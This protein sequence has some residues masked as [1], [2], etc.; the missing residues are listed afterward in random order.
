MAVEAHRFNYSIQENVSPANSLPYLPIRLNY[1]T[2]AVDVSALLD[3]GAT[4]NVLPY[5]IGLELGAIWEEQSTSVKLSGN[6]AQ[7]EAKALIV[8]GKLGNFP[9]IRLAFAWTRND[10]IPV[11]LGQVNFFM[12]FDVCFFRSQSTFEI[13]PK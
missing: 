7:Q 3:T 13:T 2:Q 6:L 11:I 8:T 10:K 4:V 1:Q 9:S 5:Q 12:E